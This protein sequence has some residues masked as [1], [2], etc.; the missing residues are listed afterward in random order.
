MTLYDPF[1]VALEREITRTEGT[2][3]SVWSVGDRPPP[4]LVTTKQ[5]DLKT[6]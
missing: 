2:R 5:A 6:N 3:N 4:W 1:A